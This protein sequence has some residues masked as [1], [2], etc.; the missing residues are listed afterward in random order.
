MDEDSNAQA[1]KA[2]K[3]FWDG[4]YQEEKIGWDLAGP[5]PLVE[6][7]SQKMN[8]LA[9]RQQSSKPTVWVPG[10]GYGHDV[11]YWAQQNFTAFGIDFSKNAIEYASR[12]YSSIN[13]VQF[14]EGD[15][16]CKDNYDFKFDLIYDRAMWVALPSHL[17]QKYLDHCL[18]CLKPKGL[19]AS[20]TFNDTNGKEGPPW[21]IGIKDQTNYMGERAALLWVEDHKR[22]DYFPECLSLWEKQ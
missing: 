9:I 14:I 12:K 21:A 2:T 17:Q 20:I 22:P 19:F 1:Y 11:V 18:A 16:F 10:C 15:L 4:L 5:H 8:S 13:G 7:I 6:R 3:E